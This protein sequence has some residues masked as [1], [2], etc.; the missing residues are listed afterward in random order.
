MGTL[1]RERRVATSPRHEKT[2]LKKILRSG[3]TFA[4]FTER[5][6]VLRETC[7]ATGD[8]CQSHEKTSFTQSIHQSIEK[9]E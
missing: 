7:S 1:S 2:T 5:K 6:R 8:L 4:G 9:N 3:F